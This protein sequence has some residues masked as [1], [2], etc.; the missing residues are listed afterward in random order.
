M[1]WQFVLKAEAEAKGDSLSLTDGDHALNV[2]REGTQATLWSVS[3]AEGPKPLNSP[4]PGFSIASFV[5]RAGD[6]GKASAKVRF[7]LAK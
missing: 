4:N 1:H 6:D 2:V 7:A 5:V 3:E